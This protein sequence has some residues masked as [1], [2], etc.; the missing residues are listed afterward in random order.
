M[1]ILSIGRPENEGEFGNGHEE[2]ERACQE[3][4]KKK[5]GEEEEEE[6]EEEKEKENFFFKWEYELDWQTS[7][8]QEA[9]EPQKCPSKAQPPKRPYK[10]LESCLNQKV[11]YDVSHD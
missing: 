1:E 11:L 7:S 5:R 6:E 8:S 4:E 2:E 10:K 3:E 9:L